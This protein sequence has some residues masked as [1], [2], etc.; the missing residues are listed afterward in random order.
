M[1]NG[2]F[3]I[4]L[5]NFAL[6]LCSNVLHVAAMSNLALSHW[7]PQWWQVLLLGLSPGGGRCGGTTA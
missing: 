4:L 2:L 7:R 1:G 5:L 3:F 6:F